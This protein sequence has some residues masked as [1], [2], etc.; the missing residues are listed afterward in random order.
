MTGP[1]PSAGTGF[2]TAPDGRLYEGWRVVTASAVVTLMAVGSIVYGFGSIFEP[3]RTE[4]GWST[5]VVSL[6]F[7]LRSEV[8][9]V[10]APFVGAALDRVGPRRVVRSGVVMSSVGVLALSFTT[11]VWWFFASVALLAVGTTAAGGQAGNH[12]VATWFRARRARAM[13]MTTMGGA[14]AGVFAFLVA[15]GVDRIGWRDTLR[16]LAVVIAVVGLVV[17]RWIRARPGDH[18]QPVDGIATEVGHPSVAAEFDIPY[19]VA[20]ATSSFRRIVGFNIV[21]DF[22]RLAYLTHLVAFV[23]RDLGAR[24]I[25]AGAALMI[26]TLASLVGRLAAG[27]FADRFAVQRVAA[28]TMA[29]FAA[30]VLVLAV[31][32]EPWHAYGAAVLG[33]IGFGASV[34]VRPAMYVEFFGLAAFG[35]IMGLGRLA[36]TTGG[37]LGGALFGL[38]VDAAAGSYGGAWLVVFAASVC[39]APLVLL[40]RPPTELQERHRRS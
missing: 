4:L 40:V 38:L 18:P 37:F 3:L 10:A 15:V 27:Y 11:T 13:S 16:V 24:P 5:F 1:T 36:S 25:A 28:L 14:L 23:E 33:G 20:I 19:R 21:A 31:A 39:S 34:P 26:S 2:F 9:G 35:R 6:G 12:A 7:S 32:S 22:G 8:G 30:G 17:S 29:P